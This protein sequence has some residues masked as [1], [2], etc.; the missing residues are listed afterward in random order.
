MRVDEKVVWMVFQ[1]VDEKVAMS[2][3]R[4]VDEMVDWK[5]HVKAVL[6]VVRREFGKV[7]MRAVLVGEWE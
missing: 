5:V 2:V 7:L 6:R 3:S 1:M 4:M